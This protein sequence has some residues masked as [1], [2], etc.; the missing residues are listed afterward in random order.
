M[1][2]VGT[3]TW[4]APLLNLGR[5]CMDFFFLVLPQQQNAS[6]HISTFCYHTGGAPRRSC[7]QAADGTRHLEPINHFSVERRSG[8]ARREVNEIRKIESWKH[9]FGSECFFF[10]PRV[11]AAREGSWMILGVC[12]VCSAVLPQVSHVYMACDVWRS[13]ATAAAA[14]WCSLASFHEDSKRRGL[15]CQRHDYLWSYHSIS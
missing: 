3:H 13:F 9:L 14:A 2:E 4:A 15:V 6:Q 12:S 11:V 8:I 5:R 10:F 7:K 1:A